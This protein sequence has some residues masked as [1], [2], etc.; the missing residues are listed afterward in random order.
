[1]D[2][3]SFLE[4]VAKG[5]LVVGSLPY[6]VGCGKD[7]IEPLNNKTTVKKVLLSDLESPSGL[8]LYKNSFNLRKE[9]LED[10]VVFCEGPIGNG[11]H[12]IE[13]LD[14]Y[15]PKV[16]KYSKDNPVQIVYEFPQEEYNVDFESSDQYA[17]FDKITHKPFGVRPLGLYLDTAVLNEG[18]ILFSSNVSKRIYTVGE[19]GKS[20][21]LEDE[22][23]LGIEQMLLGSDGKL[24]CSQAELFNKQGEMIREKRVISIDS[25]KNIK[26]EFT[27]PNGS[28]Q[29]GPAKPV[30]DKFG[31]IIDWVNSIKMGS[32]LFFVENANPSLDS[33]KFYMI[34]QW[35]RVI[36]KIS[37]DNQ[38]NILKNNLRYPSSLAISNSGLLFTTMAPLITSHGPSLPT[39]LFSINPSTGETNS[40]YNFEDIYNLEG[41]GRY[42]PIPSIEISFQGIDYGF[43]KGF[44]MSSKIEE[45]DSEINLRLTNSCLGELEEI[46]IPKA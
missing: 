1:M 12:I 10:T 25:N 28:F 9:I 29:E 18:G 45:N 22:E 46:I 16:L 37:E 6:L 43:P 39:E 26:T 11:N 33:S 32:A 41:E 35:Q 3:R 27:L 17:A 34:D 14:G 44:K 20:I 38:V 31:G 40:I 23:L 21:Y 2:R 5:A 8:S 36:Y 30:Y 4:K 42:A 15:F 24:Y 13:F 19:Q 7:K